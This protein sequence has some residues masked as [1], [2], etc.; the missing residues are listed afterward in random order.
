MNVDIDLSTVDD[1][2]CPKCKKKKE[3]YIGS[4]LGTPAV[5]FRPTCS[6][7]E[8]LIFKKSGMT[9]NQRFEYLQ[10]PF[11]K[12]MGLKPKPNEI[13]LEKYLHSRGMSYG[14][15]RRERDRQ[16]G[17]SA[18]GGIQK[19]EQHFNKYGTNNAPTPA[20]E[21]VRQESR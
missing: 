9:D 3:K 21:K 7:E 1:Q 6:C 5:M 16:E 19:F 17:A 8:K 18:K 4:I 20:F 11:W 13:K 2:Y 15:F 14:D 10:T 12:L